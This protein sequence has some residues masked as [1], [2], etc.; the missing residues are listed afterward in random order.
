MIIKSL[1]SVVLTRT[2]K[3][4]K[5]NHVGQ[6]GNPIYIPLS[7]IS[8]NTGNGFLDLKNCYLTIKNVHFILI[9]HHEL[10]L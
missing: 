8:I 2:L 1:L 10:S 3:K 4:N 6:L 5:M 7:Y 9:H